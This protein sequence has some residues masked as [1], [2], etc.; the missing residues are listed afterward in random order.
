MLKPER[1][2]QLLELC[3]QRGMVTV[4]QAATIFGISEMTARRDF[5]ELSRR[6]GV[7]REY[8]GIRL[9][10][11]SPIAE[12]VPF[13]EKLSI[14]SPEKEHIAR[15]AVN[16]IRE[17]DTIFLGP[18]STCALIARALPRMRLRVI[19][20]SIIVLNMLQTRNDVEIWA[21]GGQYR[22]RS[23]S[24]VGPIA[25]D[26]LPRSV[27]TLALSAPTAYSPN[28]SPVLTLRKD[29]YRRSLAIAP[30]SV[31]LSAIQARSDRWTSSAS[32]IS[33]KWTHSS[34]MQMSTTNSV[35][36]FSNQLASS[37]QNRPVLI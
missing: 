36:W 8:G 32:S 18:G 13:F 5:D 10:S 26:A 28:P 35:P 37:S 21:L 29:A 34:P 11:G 1:H 20:N 6:A 4:A 3:A 14:R 17:R 33:I 31:T 25:E 2:E 22:K 15:T 19:T 30:P 24:F 23:G 7:I 27:S 16:L 12:E 9:S